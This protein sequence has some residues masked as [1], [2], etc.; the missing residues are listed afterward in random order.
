MLL[1][2]CLGWNENLFRIKFYLPT[3]QKKQ[4]GYFE[5]FTEMFAKRFSQPNNEYCGA[6]K[7]RIEI[8]EKILSGEWHKFSLAVQIKLQ[9]I[10]HDRHY[11]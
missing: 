8:T 9:N 10:F 3:F 2:D 5:I 11:F 6:T 1:N 7:L 4:L